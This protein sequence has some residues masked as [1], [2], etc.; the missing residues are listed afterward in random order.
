VLASPL[1]S[2]ACGQ[3]LSPERDQGTVFGSVTVNVTYDE[4]SVKLKRLV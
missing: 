2:K 3:K 4:K 1:K